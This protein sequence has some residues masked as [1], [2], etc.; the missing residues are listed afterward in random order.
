MT[1]PTGQISFADLRNEFGGSN[2]VKLGDYY[3]GGARVPNTSGNSSVPTSGTISLNQLR[4]KSAYTNLALSGAASASMDIPANRP[5]ST[6]SVTPNWSQ[7]GGNGSPSYSWTK[8]SGNA[9]T[10]A[11]ATNV[12]NPTFSATGNLRPLKNPGAS[13]FDTQTDVWSLTV[14]DGVSSAT[15]TFTISVTRETIAGT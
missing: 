13:S 8:T 12:L 6:Q 14:S 7:T 11:S 10:S 5:A 2:P 3:R 4:G 15:K 1:T 9:S